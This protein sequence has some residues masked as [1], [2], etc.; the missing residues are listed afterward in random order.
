M[1]S[2]VDADRF[3]AVLGG[4][5]QRLCARQAVTGRRRVLAVDGKTVRGSRHIDAAGVEVAGRHLLAVIDQRTRVVLG[6]VA[7]DATVA[8]K[9][10]EIDQFSPLLDTLT[11]VDLAGCGDHCGRVALPA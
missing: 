9:A 3:D 10:S 8:G 11:G 6:Q 2:K 1:L 7:V 4:F 5:V